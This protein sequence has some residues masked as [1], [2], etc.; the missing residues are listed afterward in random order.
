MSVPDFARI[1]AREVDPALTLLQGRIRVE[2][3][4]SIAPRLG[5][6]FGQPSPY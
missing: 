4:L 1:V 5:E 2:G 6:M 3:D